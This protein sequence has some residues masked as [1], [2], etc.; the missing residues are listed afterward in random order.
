MGRFKRWLRGA[1]WNQERRELLAELNERRPL[2]IQMREMAAEQ[3]GRANFGDQETD[4]ML[5]EAAKW[6][7]RCQ[8]AIRH[9][10]SDLEAEADKFIT[11]FETGAEVTMLGAERSRGLYRTMEERNSE[12]VL[13]YYT[14]LSVACDFD[15][16][17]VPFDLPDPGASIMFESMEKM[18]EMVTKVVADFDAELAARGRETLEDEMRYAEAAF[19]ALEEAVVQS[20]H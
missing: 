2:L 17:P 16:D 19:K 12:Q 15:I 4:R 1:V 13:S 14:T 5:R 10:R 8:L 11:H 18:G 20:L 3:L 9:G 6:T 7:R